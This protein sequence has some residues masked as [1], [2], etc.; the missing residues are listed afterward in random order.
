[1][2][3]RIV[4]YSRS[5]TT[6]LLAD[7][8]SARLVAEEAEIACAR[9]GPGLFGWLRAGRDAMRGVRPE[10]SFNVTENRPDCL[11]VGGPIWAGTIAAPLRSYVA[12]LGHLPDRIGVFL[13]SGGPPPH[14]KAEGE[15]R[16]LLGRAPDAL[17]WL[18]AADVREGRHMDEVEDFFRELTHG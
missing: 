11:I 17:L 6:R 13:T 9:Y 16:N 12:Q 4:F 18:R 10:V 2:Q 7:A 15:I 3:S 8:I 5:G 14:P 1:M